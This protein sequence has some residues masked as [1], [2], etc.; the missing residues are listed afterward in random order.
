M[1]TTNDLIG[2]FMESKGHNKHLLK[3]YYIM[4][5]GVDVALMIETAKE[6]GTR[7]DFDLLEYMT[8]VFNYKEKVI[9]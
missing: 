9:K 8:F 7:L 2:A 5:N 4:F 1:K 6:G 3:R